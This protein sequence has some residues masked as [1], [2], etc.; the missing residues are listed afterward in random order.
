MARL[1]FLFLEEHLPF[2]YSTDNG[3]TFVATTSSP[4]T[5]TGLSD[6]TY[7]IYVQDA[8]GCTSGPN[9]ISI[10]EPNL[11][12]ATTIVTSNYSGQ[13][14]SCAGASDGQI[15]M[16]GIGGTTPYMFDFDNTGLSANTTIS[17][18]SSGTYD[19]V[20]EDAN[21]CANT[22][23]GAVTLNRPSCIGFWWSICNF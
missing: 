3:A 9:S 21:G 5:I 4:H 15:T 17:N 11:V 7:D 2:N 22:F 23:L 16:T 6:G 13:D 12:T 18:L 14:I 1:L 19:I 20:I 8:N 10:T